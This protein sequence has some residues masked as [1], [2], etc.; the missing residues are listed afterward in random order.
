MTKPTFLS[1]REVLVGTASVVIGGCL[2]GAQGAPPPP[3]P[4]FSSEVDVV[5]VLVT[6]RDK[7]GSIVKDLTKEEFVLRE[8]GRPQAISFFSRQTDLPL[9]IGLLVDTTPSESNMLDVERKA[10]MAFLNRMLRPQDKAFLIQYY[11]KVEVLQGLTSSREALEE[12][13]DRLQSHDMRD[14]RGDGGPEGSGQGQGSG[15]GGR[16]AWPPQGGRSRQPGGRGA[17]GTVLADAICLASND[18]MR[19]QQG[20]KALFIL[21]DG[22]HVGDSAKQA[23]AAAQQADTLIYSIRIYDKRRGGG[24]GWQVQTPGAG[25][26]GGGIGVGGGLG[27]GMGGG[28]GGG[29]GFGGGGGMGGPGGGGPGGGGPGG[30]SSENGKKNLQTLSK[31]TGGAYFEVGKDETLA[32]VYERIEEELRSQYSLGYTSDAGGPEGYRQIKVEVKRKHLVVRGRE[33]YF[34]RKK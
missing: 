23:M 2:L 5:Q 21:G 16:N 11:D 29:G 33:G 13:L 17:Y 30:M 4:T 6:V 10:S 15:Q 1:R 24:N 27:G 20:R 26:R 3:R 19:S 31:E 8:D 32:Q 14:S 22:D 7:Q 28:M 34:A 12:G 25:G 18:I 9:T